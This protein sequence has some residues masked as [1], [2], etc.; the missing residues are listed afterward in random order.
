MDNSLNFS[1]LPNIRKTLLNSSRKCCLLRRLTLT[2]LS[3]I[4]LVTDWAHYLPFLS[5]SFFSHVTPNT[6]SCSFASVSLLLV[7]PKLLKARIY[8]CL[9]CVFPAPRKVPSTC[10][11]G[12]KY[13]LRERNNIR[14]A[15]SFPH[16]SPLSLCVTISS[17][18]SSP[19]SSLSHLPLSPAPHPHNIIITFWVL[20][21]H[22]KVWIIQS[23]GLW[24]NEKSLLQESKG[25]KSK[26]KFFLMF[27]CGKICIT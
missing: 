12:N 18:L 21:T 24:M 27:I 7:E 9:T 20:Q 26:K 19:S 13:F 6:L 25:K 22:C 5:L 14:A 16:A 4:A 15:M 8:F 17:L 10:E 2:T 11:M 23:C 1:N 3:G